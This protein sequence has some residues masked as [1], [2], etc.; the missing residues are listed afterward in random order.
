[1]HAN[2]NNDYSDPSSKFI[3]TSKAN[4]ESINTRVKMYMNK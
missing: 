3:I 4:K 1:M 2:A